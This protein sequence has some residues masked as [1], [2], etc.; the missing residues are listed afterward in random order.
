[1]LSGSFSEINNAI[2]P[3]RIIFSTGYLTLSD[4]FLWELI[5]AVVPLRL[6]FLPGINDFGFLY[7]I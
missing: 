1:M 5:H 7:G 6:I 2:V 4:S 3:L